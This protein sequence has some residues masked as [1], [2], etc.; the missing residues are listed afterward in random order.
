MRRCSD[1]L[2]TPSDGSPQGRDGELQTPRN[3]SIMQRERER[4]REKE[5]ERERERETQRQSPDVEGFWNI[6]INPSILLLRLGA[7]KDAGGA[8]REGNIFLHRWIWTS[9]VDEV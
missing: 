8:C 3:S 9:G 1:Q 7:G 4:E 2:P 6:K 5:K